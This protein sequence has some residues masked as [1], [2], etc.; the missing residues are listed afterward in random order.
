MKI[1]HP[2]CHFANGERLY[3]ILVDAKT[4]LFAAKKYVVDCLTKYHL[5]ASSCGYIT[6]G[7][8]DMLLRVWAEEKR[9]ADFAQTL[10]NNREV[11]LSVKP[12]IIESMRTW[13]QN[14]MEKRQ[15]FWVSF[16]NLPYKDLM[17]RKFN[18]YCTI[19]NAKGAKINGGIRFFTFLEK[20]YGRMSTLFHDLCPY[21]QTEGSAKYNKYFK[22]IGQISIYSYQAT[23][24]QGVLLKG[25]TDNLA[26][27]TKCIDSLTKN[28]HV[29][30]T[31][32][33]CANRLI[34]E[35]DELNPKQK[36][37]LPLQMRKKPVIYNM[38]KSHDCYIRRFANIENATE[39]HERICE[40]L[41]QLIE[42]FL[43]Y[44]KQWW[45]TVD[46][47]RKLYRWVVYQKNAPLKG[48]L[49]EQYVT[50]EKKYR[51]EI[52]RYVN[53]KQ[54]IKKSKFDEVT[55]G[56]INRHLGELKEF[57]S[58][59]SKEKQAIGQ[60]GKTIHD[61]FQDRNDL[62]H[63]NVTYLFGEDKEGKGIWVGYV[64]HLVKL[65]FAIIRYQ[66]VYDRYLSSFKFERNKRK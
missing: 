18:D 46:N 3:Y 60:L 48:F 64:L 4:N 28:F 38:L 13:Y 45:S 24:H 15:A 21:L 29:L 11:I 17:N 57:S 65:W 26:N 42:G 31:T 56:T 43:F 62:M 58:L 53:I 37:R 33:L 27:L 55:W 16:K 49:M 44:N 1:Y 9:L 2:I 30:T 8:S 32:C 59:S 47:L 50:L 5:K 25:Q 39:L 7:P 19:M 34:V 40:I 41:T 36:S 14:Q 61:C 23:N 51:N 52:E 10:R 22:N 66:D 12:R 54:E 63:G 35:K 6:F 20:P